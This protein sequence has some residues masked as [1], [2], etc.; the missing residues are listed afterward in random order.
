MKKRCEK[1]LC[2]SICYC[3]DYPLIMNK[4]ENAFS[5]K[6]PDQAISKKDFAMLMQLKIEK[7]GKKLKKWEI[8]AAVA[9]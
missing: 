8:L 5:P 9:T 1:F 3:L 4:T 6:L 7:V 2:V